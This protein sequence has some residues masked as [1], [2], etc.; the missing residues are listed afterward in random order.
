MSS[1]M[2]GCVTFLT[3]LP[4]AS[5]SCFFLSMV[6]WQRAVVRARA[7]VSVVWAMI[8]TIPVAF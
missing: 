5:E 1:T 8:G 7:G 3:P 6:M 2:F 4:D